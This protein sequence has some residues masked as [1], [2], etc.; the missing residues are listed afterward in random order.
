MIIQKETLYFNHIIFNSKFLLDAV[1]ELCTGIQEDQLRYLEVGQA[2]IKTPPAI[3]R[4]LYI[5]V[6]IKDG[7][8]ASLRLKRSQL[9]KLFVNN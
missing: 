8:S 2:V 3:R 7:T 1:M 4:Y 9:L 5:Y 6:E